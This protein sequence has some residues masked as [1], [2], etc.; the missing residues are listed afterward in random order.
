MVRVCRRFKLKA[1]HT[2]H[3]SPAAGIGPGA[4]DLA[5]LR[6]GLGGWDWGFGE[7]GKASGRALAFVAH[8]YLGEAFGTVYDIS[9][10]MILWFAGASA[11]AGLLNIVP[12]YLP[13]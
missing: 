3:H 2:R 11:L 9:T 8:T 4:A 1:I 10:I 6:V 5:A 12:R 13:R 7:G